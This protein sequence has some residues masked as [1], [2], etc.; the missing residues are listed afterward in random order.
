MATIK[1]KRISN[2]WYPCIKHDLD[3]IN[4]FNDKISKYLNC[5]DNFHTEELTFDFK[6]MGIIWDC[7]NIICFNEEDIIRYLTTDEDFELRFTI[8]G[9]EFTIHSDLYTSL[10]EQFH[11]DFHKTTY[12]IDIY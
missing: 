5:L 7:E 12:L 10:E 2:H 9:R 6:E 11:F 4:G 3:Y 1:V 8:N